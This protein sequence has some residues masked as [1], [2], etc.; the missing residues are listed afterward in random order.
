MPSTERGF[1]AK[2]FDK[3]TEIPIVAIGARQSNIT[4]TAGWLNRDAERG[5]SGPRSTTANDE[6]TRS[7]ERS[8]RRAARLAGNRAERLC[9]GGTVYREARGREE[10][11]AWIVLAERGGRNDEEWTEAGELLPG[12]G[13]FRGGKIKLNKNYR[14]KETT[15]APTRGGEGD[16]NTICKKARE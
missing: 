14:E 2:K 12:E 9:D 13:G 11:N 3:S 16:E 10:R 5:S 1:S 4:A 6:L 15:A 8:E 7:A